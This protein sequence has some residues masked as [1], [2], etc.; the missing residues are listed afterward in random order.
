MRMRVGGIES[1]WFAVR[2]TNKSIP[3]TIR[4]WPTAAAAAQLTT[5]LP[6][7]Q[8]EGE[9]FKTLANNMS[10]SGCGV[11]ADQE[12]DS[13]TPFTLFDLFHC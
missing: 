4:E 1:Q 11:G 9:K 5:K 2:S 10:G 8:P 13:F 12:T 7:T 3:S 6:K